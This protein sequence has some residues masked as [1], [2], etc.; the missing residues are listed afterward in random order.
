MGAELKHVR[1]CAGLPQRVAEEAES[2]VKKYFE[3]V[4]GFP[5]EVVAVAVDSR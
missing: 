2:L 1:E 5:A 3:V 4:R